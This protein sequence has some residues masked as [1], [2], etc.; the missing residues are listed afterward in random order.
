[1]DHASKGLVAAVGDQDRAD[2]LLGM[3]SEGSR[4]AGETDR[5]AEIRKMAASV[6]HLTATNHELQARIYDRDDAP[7]LA[8]VERE[9]SRS[10][11]ALAHHID[12]DYLG[13]LGAL[14]Q[15]QSRAAAR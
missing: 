8:E 2:E 9:R 15:R 5:D 13:Y 1:M 11:A 12:D 6:A 10:F 4:S 14:L 3:I 7:G